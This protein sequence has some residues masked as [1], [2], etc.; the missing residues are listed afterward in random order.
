MKTKATAYNRLLDSG[1][2]VRAK[3]ISEQNFI[4]GHVLKE[5]EIL[6]SEFDTEKSTLEEFIQSIEEDILVCCLAQYEVTIV[7]GSM[8]N[9]FLMELQAKLAAQYVN[10]NIR[11]TNLVQF[12]NR[13]TLLLNRCTDFSEILDAVL[14]SYKFNVDEHIRLHHAA[15]KRIEF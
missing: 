1:G 2:I 13:A 3:I 11:V 14:L 5:A 7:C 4:L 12:H 6:E 8:L 9:L 10:F 15:P